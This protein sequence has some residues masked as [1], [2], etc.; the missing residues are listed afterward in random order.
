[1][2]AL[3]AVEFEPDTNTAAALHAL[4]RPGLIV[5][6]LD[7]SLTDAVASVEVVDLDTLNAAL[8]D[9]QRCRCVKCGAAF[10]NAGGL[11]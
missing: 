7:V 11:S 3:L 10:P 8:R 5:T 4:K 6:S 1:M 9:V 2:T